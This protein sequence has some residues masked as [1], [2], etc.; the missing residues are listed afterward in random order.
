[1][2]KK[3]I[4]L[5]FLLSLAI[6]VVDQIVKLIIVQTIP[7]NTIGTEVIGDFFRII[8]VRNTGIAFSF[9]DDFAPVLRSV[10]FIV[11]PLAVLVGLTVYTLRTTEFTRLQRWAIAGIVGGGIGNLV[12][13]I[14]RPE[15][16]VDFLDFKFFGLFGMERFPTFN[17]ADS[18]VT[19]SGT[20]LFISLLFPAKAVDQVPAGQ[21]ASDKTEN[22]QENTGVQ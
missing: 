10:L 18:F 14:F 7:V 5:P 16:V 1:M 21:E 20:L 3:P 12:D 15:G 11:L 19:I 17:V 22:H 4:W 8:H 6:V 9:G 13:R 2:N